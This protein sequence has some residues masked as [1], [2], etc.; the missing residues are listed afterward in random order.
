MGQTCQSDAARRHHNLTRKPPF[1][2]MRQTPRI[3]ANQA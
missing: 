2:S 3:P 1:G